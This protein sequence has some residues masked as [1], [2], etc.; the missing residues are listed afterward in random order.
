MAMSPQGAGGATPAV[1]PP[2]QELPVLGRQRAEDRLQGRQAAAAVRV[3]A[4]QDR[5]EPHHRGLGEEAA[6]ARPSDQ[7]RALSWAAALRDPLR[8][9]GQ[10]ERRDG[11]DPARTGAQTRP[12]G[13]GGARQRRLRPQFPAAAR[14]GAARHRRKIARRFETMKSDLEARSLALKTERRSGRREA[15]RQELHCSSPGFGSRP[16]VRIGFAARSRRPHH[17]SR[18]QRNR[19]QIALNTP[20]KTIGQHNVPISLHPEI[21]T[22]DHSDRRPQ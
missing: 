7:A 21:E 19:N 12:D 13:R 16:A 20:I 9:N 3:R 6:R 5:S 2:P 11:S 8:S 15:Q 18:I 22:I 17:D 14:Q 4:R 1:L 10:G